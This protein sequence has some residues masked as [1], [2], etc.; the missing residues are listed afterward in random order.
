MPMTTGSIMGVWLNPGETV[1]W[2]WS[3]PMPGERHVTGYNIIQ[4][5]EVK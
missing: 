5:G 4:Q 2:I 3:G 1:Q